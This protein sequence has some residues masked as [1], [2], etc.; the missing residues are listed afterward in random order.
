[1]VVEKVVSLTRKPVQPAHLPQP[2][3]VQEAPQYASVA[4]VKSLDERLQRLEQTMTRVTERVTSEISEA[5]D[6]LSKEGESRA[7]RINERIDSLVIAIGELRGGEKA[8]SQTLDSL[9]AQISVARGGRKP[10]H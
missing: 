1:M 2:M 10:T 3:I 7:V 8:H 4:G 9:I 5:E 6:A